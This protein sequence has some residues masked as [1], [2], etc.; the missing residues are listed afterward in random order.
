M[1]DLNTIPTTKKEPKAKPKRLTPAA[2]QS[3]MQ[4][5]IQK[6][7]ASPDDFILPEG[8]LDLEFFLKRE[9]QQYTPDQIIHE[10]FGQEGFKMTEQEKV[11]ALL[12]A[13]ESL[14]ITMPFEFICESCTKANPIA[15]EVAK[16]MQTSGT[17]KQRF[18]V[19]VKHNNKD[20]IF[21]LDRPD[22]LQDTSSMKGLA[23]VGMYILQWLVGHNQGPDFDFLQLPLPVII[24]LA[25]AFNNEI[26][27]V[28]FH[29]DSKC[30]FCKADIKQDFFV[31]MQDLAEVINQL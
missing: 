9:D 4:S 14:E 8:K 25:E 21:E 18:R 13:M 23:A 2:I 15:V 31:G 1:L 27:H 28:N 19:S 22:H 29:V 16:V 24:K 30:A 17:S 5:S 10:V 7:T 20:Y 11:Y 26:F 6:A 3:S 12:K